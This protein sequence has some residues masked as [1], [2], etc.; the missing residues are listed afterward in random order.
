MHKNGQVDQDVVWGQ[1]RVASRLSHVVAGSA[2]RHRL[3]NMME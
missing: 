2:R 3:A 1:K